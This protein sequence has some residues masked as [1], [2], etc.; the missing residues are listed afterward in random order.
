MAIHEAPHKRI[1]NARQSPQEQPTTAQERKREIS[2]CLGSRAVT[3]YRA[4]FTDGYVLVSTNA[5]AKCKA[6]GQSLPTHAWRGTMNRN[7]GTMYEDGG[8]CV[9][10]QNAA[11]A[12]SRFR[13]TIKPRKPAFTEVVLAEAVT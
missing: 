13:L 7:N 9:S 10:E 11:L 3:A 5:A 12:V 2:Y 1:K 8:F 6:K 4:K